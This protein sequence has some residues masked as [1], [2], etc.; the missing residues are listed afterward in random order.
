MHLSC[1][2][3]KKIQQL[4]MVDNEDDDDEMNCDY[5]DNDMMIKTYKIN[6]SLLCAGRT[7]RRVSGRASQYNRQ[8]GNHAPETSHR[9]G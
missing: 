6:I 5:Y 2:L 9:P 8:E 1:V 3:R 7:G 4:R